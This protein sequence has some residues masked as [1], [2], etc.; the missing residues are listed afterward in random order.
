[1]EEFIK[2]N[3]Q[4][5][6]RDRQA[7]LIQYLSRV[8]WYKLQQNNRNG[9]ETFK[10]LEFH[11]SS[12]RKLLRFG[13]CVDIVYSILPLLKHKDPT[14]RTTV[15]LS[16]L[17]TALF[18]LGDHILW[19]GRS[20]LCSVNTD[21]WGRLSTQYWF[22]SLI[23][24]LLRDLYEVTNILKSHKTSLIPSK[25]ISSLPDVLKVLT[26]SLL[27]LQSHRNVLI[28]I[29]KNGCDIFIP[30]TSLG[31]TKLSPSTV[32]TL[33]VISS[34]AGL[35]IVLNPKNKLSP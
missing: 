10:N 30:M 13:K 31:Y 11:L 3:G 18:L 26:T 19:L 22:Y 14:I 25:G 8:I 28:D 24:N 4:T 29:I 16:R 21:K 34:I 15:I 33:G 5:V 9:V 35:L 32:G 17:N 12:F 20:D 1:M 6:G 27:L 7:R 2:L 23:F